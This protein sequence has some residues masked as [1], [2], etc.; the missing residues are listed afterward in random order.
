MAQRN[1]LELQDNLDMSSAPDAQLYRLVTAGRCCQSKVF[2]GRHAAGQ[3]AP[4]HAGTRR[5]W[6]SVGPVAPCNPLEV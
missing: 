3:Q 6:K 4:C 1:P 5:N 2:H